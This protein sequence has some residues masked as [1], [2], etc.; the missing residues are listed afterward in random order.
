MKS[1]K[2]IAKTMAYLDALKLT[3]RPKIEDIFIEQIVGG[4]KT[5]VTCSVDK[6]KFPVIYS[7]TFEELYDYFVAMVNN[8]E[9]LEKGDIRKGISSLCQDEEFVVDIF[10]RFDQKLRIDIPTLY[11]EGELLKVKHLF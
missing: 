10:D 3:Q 1:Y 8:K 9:H 7:Y 5:T 6:T 11:V 4:Y 2:K